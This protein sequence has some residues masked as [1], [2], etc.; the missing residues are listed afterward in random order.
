MSRWFLVWV[1]FITATF[2]GAVQVSQEAATIA[3]ALVDE[4]QTREP[5][6]LQV[7]AGEWTTPLEQELLS[8]LLA[9]GMDVRMSPVGST[10]S[11]PDSLSNPLNLAAYGIDSALLLKI[12]LNLKW[13]E[14]SSTGFFSYHSQ[15]VPVY[16]FTASQIS[17]PGWRIVKQSSFDFHRPNLQQTETSGLRLKWFE[18]LIAS[19]AIVSLVFLLW[20]FN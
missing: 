1:M 16:S 6:I 8:Q 3:G 10:P 17:L 11:E 14:H 15:R 4:I 13:E 18:P 12:G 9:K 19:A 5:V 2:L 20:N 7:D